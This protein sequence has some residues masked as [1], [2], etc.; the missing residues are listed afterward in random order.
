MIYFSNTFK[1][2]ITFEVIV[3][4]SYSC[5]DSSTKALILPGLT[6]DTNCLNQC[7]IDVKMQLLVWM[8]RSDLTRFLNLFRS[9]CIEV[10]E[11][12]EGTRL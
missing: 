7:K 5:K 6:P 11:N 4:F 3:Y 1:K 9:N 2:I 10:S 8:G 12:L